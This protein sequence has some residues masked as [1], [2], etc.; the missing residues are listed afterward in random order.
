MQVVEEPQEQ[1]VAVVERWLSCVEPTFWRWRAVRVEA[2]EQ[3][4][5]VLPVE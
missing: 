2:E 5:P 3:A 1:A 4:T